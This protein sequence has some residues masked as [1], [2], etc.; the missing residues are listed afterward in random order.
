MGVMAEYGMT[1][2]VYASGGGG[3]DRKDKREGFIRAAEQD[4]V[5]KLGFGEF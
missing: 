1:F 5:D 2:G 4:A 3:K